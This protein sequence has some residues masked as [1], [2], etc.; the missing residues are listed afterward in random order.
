MLGDRL[1]IARYRGEAFAFPTK[2]SMSAQY[3]VNCA[4]PETE[5]EEGCEDGGDLAWAL[6]RAAEAGVVD[7]TCAS[8]RASKQPCDALNV[9]VNCFGA[10]E[11]VADYLVYN[12]SDYGRVDLSGSDH[13][14]LRAQ[15]DRGPVACKVRADASLPSR[16]RPFHASVVGFFKSDS[17][18]R[19]QLADDISRNAR[20]HTHTRAIVWL[21]RTRCFFSDLFLWKRRP[22]TTTNDD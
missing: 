18:S 21:E 4:M 13:A 6:A 16:D 12:V 8:Y 19:V 17:H 3:F 2:V 9:C 7:E 20:A 11:A 14:R 5:E 10:C 1:T 22:T 15:V